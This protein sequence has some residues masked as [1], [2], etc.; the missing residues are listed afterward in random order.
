MKSWLEEIEERELKK[1][2]LSANTEQRIQLKTEKIAANYLQNKDHYENFISNLTGLVQK[3]NSLPNDEKK[4]FSQI[5]IQLKD[6]NFNNKLTVF[7]SST[8]FSISK[9][10]YLF[11]GNVVF[12]FKHIRV[13]YFSIS[14]ELG[15]INIEYK[16]KYLS[17]GNQ[18]KHIKE[19]SHFSYVL[20]FGILSDELAYQII[21]WLAFKSE[22][23]ELHIKKQI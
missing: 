16:E 9:K 4:D 19:D 5:D 10:K 15:K 14:K 11:F 23:N 1:A 2:A 3:A 8:R 20:D 7:S 13:F 18:L 6:T 17:K 12:R 21:N 22:I